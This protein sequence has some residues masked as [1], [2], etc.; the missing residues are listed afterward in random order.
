MEE[1]AI[2]AKLNGL[3]KVKYMVLTF[4]GFSVNNGCM[5]PTMKMI[6]KKI[7]LKFKERLDRIYKEI[8]YGK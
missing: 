5:T 2:E 3:E 6:R 1:N 4:E 8:K 7:E